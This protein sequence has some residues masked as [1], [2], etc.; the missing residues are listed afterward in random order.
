[1]NDRTARER[2]RRQGRGY[3]TNG[4]GWFVWDEDPREVARAAR[5]LQRGAG[6][7]EPSEEMLGARTPKAPSER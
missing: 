1:M 7:Q 2:T 6:P 4:P 5:E 3:C